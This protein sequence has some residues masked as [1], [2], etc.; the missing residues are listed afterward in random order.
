MKF[1]QWLRN[2]GY[3]N[4]TISQ[5]KTIIKYFNKYDYI[6]MINRPHKSDK[7]YSHKSS[8]IRIYCRYLAGINS[9]NKIPKSFIKELKEFY[10][11]NGYKRHKINI[12]R[13]HKGLYPITVYS[14]NNRY[15]KEF[16]EYFGNKHRYITKVMFRIITTKNTDIKNRREIDAV[17]SYYRFINRIGEK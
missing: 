14:G 3:C 7:Y 9:N 4:I 1:E 2:E 15:H 8:V 12:S 11:S 16:K 6:D 13:I 5:S 17:Y 10:N